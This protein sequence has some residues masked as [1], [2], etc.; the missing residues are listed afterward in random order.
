MASCPASRSR[1]ASD[2]DMSSSMTKEA[3]LTYADG[4]VCNA[5]CRIP[6]S[7]FN[8][9]EVDAI[10]ILD[11]SIGHPASQLAQDNCDRHASA[12][13]DGLTVAHFVVHSDSRRDF[14]RVAH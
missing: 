10:F 9:L 5:V 8:A 7:S 11:L 3:H 1:P 12:F 4:L 2:R 6:E 14:N 13:N